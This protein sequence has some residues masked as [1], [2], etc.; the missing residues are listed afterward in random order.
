[1][2]LPFRPPKKKKLQ[3]ATARRVRGADYVE[4]P[5]IRLSSAFVVVLILHIVAVGGIY[6]FNAIKAHQPPAFEESETTAPPPVQPAAAQ[7]ADNTPA[8]T[9]AIAANPA[10][11]IEYRVKSGDTILRIASL[12]GVSAADIIDLNNVRADGGIHVGEEIKLPAGAALAGNEAPQPV[13]SNTGVTYTVVRG[14]TLHAIARRFHV[15]FDELMRVNN[16]DD[17]RK[18]R[19]GLKLKIPP[20][21][22]ASATSVT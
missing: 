22:S 18:L 1:M 11:P 20:R 6:A 2:K 17:P 4:E 19:I 3:A 7:T 12:Y 10:P 15:T 9:A 8:T 13:S 21:H 5:N 14:D 16:I